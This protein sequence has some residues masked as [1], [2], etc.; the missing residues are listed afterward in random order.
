MRLVGSPKPAAEPSNTRLTLG[1]YIAD[2]LLDARHHEKVYHWIVQQVGSVA[3]IQW[4]QESTFEEAKAAAQSY[5][6]N[7]HDKNERKKA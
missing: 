1:D 6:E 3:I 2:V 4:G 5:L 7:L